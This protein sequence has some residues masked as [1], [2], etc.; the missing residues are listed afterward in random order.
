MPDVH[1][2]LEPVGARVPNLDRFRQPLTE[3][4]RQQLVPVSRARSAATAPAA[5]DHLQGRVHR[6][7]VHVDLTPIGTG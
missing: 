2:D 4:E 6:D 1:V 3:Q 5:A 7:V